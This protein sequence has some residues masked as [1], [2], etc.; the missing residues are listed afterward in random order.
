[1]PIAAPGVVVASSS[2]FAEDSI[3]E[4]SRLCAAATTDAHT[5]YD[6]IR[7]IDLW[8]SMYISKTGLQTCFFAVGKNRSGDL[9]Y[10]RCLGRYSTVG[11][12]CSITCDE[13]VCA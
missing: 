3:A 1:M 12:A 6:A 8:K 2:A 10:L 9:F 13:F 7:E 4:T 5:K 11:P